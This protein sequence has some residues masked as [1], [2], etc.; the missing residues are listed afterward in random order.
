MTKKIPKFKNYKEE[1]K[2]WDTHDISD[3]IDEMKFVDVEF[4]PRQKREES[5]TI[6]V[7]PELKKRLDQIA[8]KNNISLSTIA[9]LWL[10]ERLKNEPSSKVV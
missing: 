10:I 6:R 2:F 5:M 4:I 9:R 8:R 3:Y 7:E 1:A